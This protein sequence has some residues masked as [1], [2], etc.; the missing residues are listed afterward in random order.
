[1]RGNDARCPA[2]LPVRLVVDDFRNF[3]SGW[4]ERLAASMREKKSAYLVFSARCHI[5]IAISR[6]AV[7]NII[8]TMNNARLVTALPLQVVDEG[9]SNMSV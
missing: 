1:M 7:P 2:R 3:S 9:A 8:A 5:T 4:L 6:P